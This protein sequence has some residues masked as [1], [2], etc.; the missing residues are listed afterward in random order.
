MALPWDVDFSLLPNNV[1]EEIPPAISSALKI[2]QFLLMRYYFATNV[3]VYSRSPPWE[4]Q[5]SHKWINCRN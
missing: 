2:Q 5:I 4:L 3:R 1:L